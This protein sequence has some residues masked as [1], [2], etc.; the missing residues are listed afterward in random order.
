MCYSII[1]VFVALRTTIVMISRE[2]NPITIDPKYV[3]G[4]QNSSLVLRLLIFLKVY[5]KLTAFCNEHQPI[6]QGI[7]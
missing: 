5:S 2:V 4:K 7:L 6:N 3:C 1:I